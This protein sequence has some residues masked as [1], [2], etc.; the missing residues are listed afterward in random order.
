MSAFLWLW[1]AGAA[2]RCVAQASH[3]GGFSRPGAR[4]LGMW[5]SLAR[6]HGPSRSTCMLFSDQGWNPCPQHWPADSWLSCGTSG[7]FHDSCSSSVIPWNDSLNSGKHFTHCYQLIIQA[8]TQKASDGRDAEGEA[9]GTAS[10]S[11]PWFARHIDVPSY[12]EA[13]GSFP[14]VWKLFH[15]T[16]MIDLI[17]IGRWWLNPVSNPC[18]FHGGLSGDCPEAI[19]PPPVSR[20][21][22]IQKTLLGTSL[23][24]HTGDTGSIAGPGRLHVL[25]S[26]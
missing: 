15:S 11:L 10:F 14:P 5:A 8:V 21:I 24:A 7:G 26:N 20:L 19:L 17:I 22:S 4:V 6:A 13:V 2:L 1:R 12:L 23:L 18:P 25:W 3:C 9:W 16:D